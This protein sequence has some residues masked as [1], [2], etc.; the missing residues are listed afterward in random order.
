VTTAKDALSPSRQGVYGINPLLIATL[1]AVSA[2]VASAECAWDLWHHH[3]STLPSSSWDIEGGY[4]TAAECTTEQTRWWDATMKDLGNR[5]KYSR[6]TG[7][8]QER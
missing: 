4:K 2:S 3:T 8:M 5:E 6:I 1:I 7:V